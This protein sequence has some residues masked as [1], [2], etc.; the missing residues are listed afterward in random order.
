[1][2]SKMG[3][4][5][6]NY[7]KIQGLSRLSRLSY[8]I[9]AP[10]ARTPLRPPCDK[11]PKCFF[12]PPSTTKSPTT[13]KPINISVMTRVIAKSSATAIFLKRQLQTGIGNV[14]VRQ[15]RINDRR[16]GQRFTSAILPPYLRRVAS[17]DN[18]IP[19]LYLRGIS[20]SEMSRALE[21]ILGE[22][23][24]GLSATNV[25]RR[26]RAMGERT[27]AMEQA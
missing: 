21:P 26:G 1:M 13:F 25:V 20:T 15:P 7:P 2:G 3:A 10:S 11:E 17:L 23:A 16:S 22:N 4:A 18:L 5:D 14:P 27:R 9:A 12:R 8:G 19:A 6:P 24:S